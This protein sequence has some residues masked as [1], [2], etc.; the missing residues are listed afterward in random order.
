[1]IAGMIPCSF[2]DYPGALSAVLFTQ[3]CNLRCRYCHNP[4]LC[5][6][7]SRTR[8]PIEDIDRFLTRRQGKLSAVTVTGGEPTIHGSL[9]DWLHLIRSRGFHVKLDTNGMRPQFVRDLVRNGLLSYV[10]VDIKT[11]PGVDGTWLT[12]S[13]NQGDR[14]LE[15]LAHVAA[16]GVACEARTTVVRQV[17][18]PVSL[19]HTARCLAEAGVR[20][21]RLQAV[22]GDNVL[23]SAMS[24]SPP[25]DAVLARAL[26]HAGR[27]GIDGALRRRQGSMG[28]LSNH[29]KAVC[30]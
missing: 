22:E 27:L 29:L 25:D 26:A 30:R 3:G 16:L 28:P 23:D 6:P 5:R 10:A 1:M 20:T 17:H 7:T 14:A 9:P 21:W 12:G 2:I 11:A 8:L 19:A 24:L 13:A 4:A 15:T 18:D